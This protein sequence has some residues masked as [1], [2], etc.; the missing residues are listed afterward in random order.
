MLVEENQESALSV[1]NRNKS[2]H[3]FINRKMFRDILTFIFLFALDLQKFMYRKTWRHTRSQPVDSRCSKIL[4]SK[5]PVKI[6][7]FRENVVILHR[8]SGEPFLKAIRI[9]GKR[10]YSSVG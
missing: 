8:F 2:T 4:F 6:W 10:S 9:E 1:K 3:F 7:Q 5:K